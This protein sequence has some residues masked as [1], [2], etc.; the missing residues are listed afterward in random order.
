MVRILSA[1]TG[2]AYI[3]LGHS[4]FIWSSVDIP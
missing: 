3:R 1:Q 4:G 2:T